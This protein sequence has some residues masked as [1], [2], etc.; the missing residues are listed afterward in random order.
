MLGFSRILVLASIAMLL[1]SA[2]AA[3]ALVDSA[4]GTVQVGGATAIP[5]QRVFAGRIVTTGPQSQATLTFDDRMQLV[6]GADTELR[7]VDFRFARGLTSDRAVLDLTRG[8][9][10]VI[11]GAVARRGET[12]FALRTPQATFAVRAGPADFTVALVNPAYLSVAGG[13]VVVSNAGGSAVFGPGATAQVANS[14]ALAAPFPP[15]LM[16]SVA[17]SAF[18]SLGTASVSPAGGVAYG[19]AGAASGAGGA[20]FGPMLLTIGAA[21]AIAA[22]ASAA[23]DNDASTTH[24]P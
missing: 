18:G 11:T 6:L 17:V 15:A 23:D 3:S 10:R 24:H 1:P 16:P 8:S 12:A 4:I 13:Q 2:V 20:A 9:L 5:G 21:A 14:A 7:I 19:A 22:A